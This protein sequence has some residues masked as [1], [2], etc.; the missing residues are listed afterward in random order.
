MVYR[1]GDGI[2]RAVQNLHSLRSRKVG[3]LLKG[4]ESTKPV[5]ANITRIMLRSAE[6]IWQSPSTASHDLRLSI[7]NGE[8]SL[9]RGGR[10]YV[11]RNA[12]GGRQEPLTNCPMSTTSSTYYTRHEE[13][14]ICLKTLIVPSLQWYVCEDLGH[15]PSGMFD[16]SGKSTICAQPSPGI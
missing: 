12:R 3:K 9:T 13:H 1:E 7:G 8:R 14:I 16:C 11:A 15:A 10:R 5:A 6:K 4:T 2:G